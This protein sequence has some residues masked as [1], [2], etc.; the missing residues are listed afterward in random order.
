VIAF[1]LKRSQENKACNRYP[2]AFIVLF[3]RRNRAIPLMR[4]RPST[5]AVIACTQAMVTSEARCLQRGAV[6][7]HAGS[8]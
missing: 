8:S 2:N 3:P 1:S 5:S 6:V 7:L 4:R